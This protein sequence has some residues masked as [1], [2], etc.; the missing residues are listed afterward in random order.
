MSAP[1]LSTNLSSLVQLGSVEGLKCPESSFLQ[2]LERRI[3]KSQLKCRFKEGGKK[4]TSTLRT[5]SW[6]CKS[7][8]DEQRINVGIGQ[9]NKKNLKIKKKNSHL[10]TQFPA[11][12]LPLAIEMAPTISNEADFARQFQRTKKNKKKTIKFETH[13][14]RM[15]RR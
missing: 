7:R 10:H 5:C 3:H 8:A 2:S 11:F 14:H 15:T 6:K 4:T 1:P 9:T 13:L 12:F